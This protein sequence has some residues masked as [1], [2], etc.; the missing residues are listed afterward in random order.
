MSGTIA[1]IAMIAIVVLMTL[2]VVARS[3]GLLPARRKVDDVG[4]SIGFAGSESAGAGGDCGS[5]GDG[6]CGG[7]D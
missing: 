7:G 4:G 2:V 3:V 1:L 6:G 5:G